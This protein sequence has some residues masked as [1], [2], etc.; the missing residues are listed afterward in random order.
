MRN[1]LV[2]VISSAKYIRSI[3]ETRGRLLASF[4]ALTLGIKNSGRD[5]SDRIIDSPSLTRHFDQS[6]DQLEPP[7]GERPRDRR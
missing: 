5:S 6:I 2:S 3:A 1:L 4:S 7:K